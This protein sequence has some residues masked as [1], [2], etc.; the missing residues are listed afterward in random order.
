MAGLCH[1]EG[2]RQTRVAA[3]MF[4]AAALPGTQGFVHRSLTGLFGIFPGAAIEFALNQAF[5]KFGHSDVIILRHFQYKNLRFRGDPKLDFL[6]FFSYEF[7]HTVVLLGTTSWVTQ[8]VC[9]DDT[10][11]AT[12]IYIG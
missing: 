7:W 12:K 4:S 8:K 6:G 11:A 10:G 1:S 9:H 2:I 3:G 5:Q